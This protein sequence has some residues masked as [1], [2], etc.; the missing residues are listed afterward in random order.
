MGRAGIGRAGDGALR[1]RH[2]L[3]AQQVGEVVRDAVIGAIRI[4][5]PVSPAFLRI[6]EQQIVRTY[7]EVPLLIFWGDG[8]R[9]WVWPDGR[10]G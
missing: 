3:V 1:G 8:L 7:S 6:G 4:P 9:G 2:V 10:G 5:V